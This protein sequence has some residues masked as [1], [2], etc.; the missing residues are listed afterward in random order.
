MTRLTMLRWPLAPV[1]LI[2]VSLFCPTAQ[3]NGN[4]RVPAEAFAEGGEVRGLD[5]APPIQYPT[6]S[7]LGYRG[8]V[9]ADV[10]KG[11][12]VSH[13]DEIVG[14]FGSSG[15]WVF[16]LT[17]I[18]G[19]TWHQ[20]SGANP[21]WI[22]GAHF[23]AVSGW[24]VVADF[25][26][27]GLWRWKHSG[28]PGTWLQISGADADGAFAVDDDN[29]GGQE[30]QVDFGSI[31]LWRY[32]DAGGAGTWHQFSSVNPYLGSKMDTYTLGYE[33]GCWLLP[34]YGVWRLWW[35][36]GEPVVQNLT[37]TVTSD[38]DLASARFIGGTG[39]DL[40]LDFGSLG[41]W[42]CHNN[43]H[44]W[45]FISALSA[46]KMREV[47]FGGGAWELLVDFDGD[48]GLHY[49]S[50]GGGFPG[51]VT[52]IIDEDPDTGFCEP[53]DPDGNMESSV[54]DEEL[55]VDRGLNGLW[56]YNSTGGVWNRLSPNDPV[57]MVRGDF[58]KDGR[59][60]ALAVDFGPL[61]LWVFDGRYPNWFQISGLSPDDGS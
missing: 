38:K 14:D 31:G 12:D 36:E 29:D 56:Q 11:N 28:Y 34:A 19:G 30:L 32:D 21:E 17:A 52:E 4:H 9:A 54:I 37:G 53:F 20:I 8:V 48:V 3:A 50:F 2:S 41:I 15:L 23:T 18:Y 7:F 61:G 1:L 60:T 35:F 13:V 27:L 25:G 26:S 43:D 44:S 46:K 22:L 39:E 47:Q 51:V 40:A 49:W 57:F 24:E 6:N 58:W 55:A 33:E 42:L 59:K 5:L 45:H 10:N 16:E